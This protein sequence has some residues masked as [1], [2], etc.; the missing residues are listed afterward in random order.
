M[1]FFQNCFLLFSFTSSSKFISYLFRKRI[2][3]LNVAGLEPAPPGSDQALWPLSHTS[4]N[5]K[6]IGLFNS[7][8]Y[9]IEPYKNSVLF[10]LRHVVVYIEIIKTAVCLHSPTFK[11]LWFGTYTYFN[12]S[13][14][15]FTFVIDVSVYTS[16]TW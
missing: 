12:V 8:P 16:K 7:L 13:I 15:A 9:V 10:L 14:I 3:N 2:K 6:N 5:V 4:I 11:V 1:E